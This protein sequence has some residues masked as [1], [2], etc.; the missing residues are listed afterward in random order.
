[1]Q[2]WRMKPDGTQKEQLT[3]D[4]NNNWFPH[5]APDGNSLVF[6][7]FP[8]DIDPA[9]HPS[10]KEV[11]LKIMQLNVPAAPRVIAHLF[12]G[13]GTI[14]VPSWSPDSKYLAF[15]SNSEKIK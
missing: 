15:V 5:I 13:Q 3:F 14:N 6:I 4:E 1:M 12:G 2:I 11:T 8:Y 9:S 10:Y 7:S